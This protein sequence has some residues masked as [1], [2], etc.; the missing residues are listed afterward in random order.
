VLPDDVRP[1]P[2]IDATD[3]S[4]AVHL[5]HSARFLRLVFA[6]ECVALA[7]EETITTPLPGFGHGLLGDIAAATTFALGWLGVVT[8]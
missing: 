4:A 3:M 2:Q 8:F 5:L 1:R 6:V 7:I